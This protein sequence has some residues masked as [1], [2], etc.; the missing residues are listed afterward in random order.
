MTSSNPH[1]ELIDARYQRAQTLM[2]GFFT[3]SIA[4]NA[5]LFPV[6][7]EGHDCFWYER[8]INPKGD[9]YQVGDSVPIWDKEYRLVNADTASNAIAF[10]HQAL[11]TA[12]G[13]T[14]GQAVNSRQL[15]IKA[16]A[17]ELDAAQ[18]V[19]EIQFAAFDK[20]W[21]YYPQTGN[22]E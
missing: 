3:R 12:L 6:W 2:Q 10:D 21:V 13:E 9:Q 14:L 20:S 19:A 15:P 16:V 7:I 22:L 1:P 11:A 5:T 18:Q 8:Q 17:M 4:P